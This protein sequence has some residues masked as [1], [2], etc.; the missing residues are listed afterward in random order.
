MISTIEKH[1]V[2]IVVP[3]FNESAS[4]STVLSSLIHHKYQVLVV[5]D[6]STDNTSDIAKSFGV[7][8]LDLPINLGVGG[9]LRAGFQYA[10]R[11]G[12]E[13]VIQIDADGQHP[14]EQIFE[15]ISASNTL[16]AS[17]VIGS[18]FL[19][20]SDSMHVSE[21]RR[22][23][24]RILA[25]SASRAAQTTITDSTSGFRIIRQPLLAKFSRN[26][27]ANYLGDTYEAIVAAGRSGYVVREISVPIKERL[28]GTS[29]SSRLKSS[30]QT[31]KVLTIAILQLHTRL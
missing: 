27:A 13:A 19:Q 28:N 12:F 29:S 11:H 15:L 10:V 1:Q 22:L 4:I 8:V 30:F 14:V 18:R 23:A 7:K 6:G 31:V 3:A 25:R 24:M 2:L 17:L 5:N 9:A 26:F 20:D 16:A 21:T